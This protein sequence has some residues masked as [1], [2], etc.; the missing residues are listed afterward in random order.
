VTSDSPRY[1]ALPAATASAI[2]PQV[3]SIGTCGSTRCSWYRSTWSVPRR[4]RLS[5]I[6]LRTCSGRPSPHDERRAVEAAGRV[7]HDQ[8][9][10]DNQVRGC[11]A[12]LRALAG[13]DTD[14]P[15]LAQL[16]GEL[17]LKSPEFARL[18]ERYD[19]RARPYGRK[20]YHHPEVGD[21]TLGYQSMQLEGT[22][23]QRLNAYYAE[24][25]TP[26]YDAMVLLDMAGSEPSSR[27]AARQRP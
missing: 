25:G 1:R 19:V 11:V 22:P 7:A 12:R 3:S 24:P 17:L 5:S 21:L 4:H 26:D 16:V 14:A 15:D 18:W 23:G 2:A 13:T 6:D 27:P 8:S 9:D 20:T 10:W